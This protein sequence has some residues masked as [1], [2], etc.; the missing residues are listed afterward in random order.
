[1]DIGLYLYFVFNVIP[2]PE[3]H[4]P[5]NSLRGSE[6]RGYGYCSPCPLLPAERIP[7]LGIKGSASCSIMGEVF[8]I[9]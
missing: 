8:T 5:K 6:K 9:P 3:H 1:M 7:E 4:N 2:D